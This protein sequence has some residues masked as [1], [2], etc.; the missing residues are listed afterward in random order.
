MS[1]DVPCPNHRKMARNTVT[2]NQHF[3]GLK[4]EQKLGEAQGASL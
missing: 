2:N 3:D 1:E 4:R